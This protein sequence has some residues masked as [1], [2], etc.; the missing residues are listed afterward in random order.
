MIS[1]IKT[2]KDTNV[3]LKMR[4][5]SVVLLLLVSGV[6]PTVMAAEFSLAQAI[7]KAQENDPWLEGSRFRQQSLEALSVQAGSLPDPTVSLGLG[8]ININN[9]DAMGK[10][11]NNYNVGISQMFSRGNSLS[12]QRRS[13]EHT[14]ELQSRPHLVCRLL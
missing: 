10:G 11:V 9:S 5:F 1:V 12:L 6:T 4:M 14:S 3:R 13:E 2:I 8:N 7:K